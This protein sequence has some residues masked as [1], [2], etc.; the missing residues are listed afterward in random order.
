MTA[1]VQIHRLGRLRGE[2]EVAN[3]LRQKK[4]MWVND[5]LF[6]AVLKELGLDETQVSCLL[7]AVGPG[8]LP[9]RRALGAIATSRDE[10]QS[11]DLPQSGPNP[12]PFA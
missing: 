3:A 6:V 12:P 9:T 2:A 11:A 5:A 8:Q 10:P 4:P 7:G 1:R